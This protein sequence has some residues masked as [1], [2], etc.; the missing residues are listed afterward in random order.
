[1]RANA[2]K[3]PVRSAIERVFARQQR[4]MCL[5]FR[6]IG[7]A[8]ARTKIGLANLVFIMQRMVWLITH[9]TAT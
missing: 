8:R 5:F 2:R 9:A 4:P 6:T 7:I 3:S 1:V